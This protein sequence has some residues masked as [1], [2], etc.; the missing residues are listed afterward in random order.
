MR[1]L[2]IQFFCI[3]VFCIQAVGAPS[4]A[5]FRCTLSVR[6]RRLQGASATGAAVR[7]SRFRMNMARRGRNLNASL[8]LSIIDTISCANENLAH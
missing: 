6:R 1:A 7:G 5:A 8:T 4:T 3:R 2:M